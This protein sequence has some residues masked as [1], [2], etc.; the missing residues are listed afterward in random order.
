M[1]HIQYAVF[2]V[3]EWWLTKPIIL[4]RDAQEDL[5]AQP[6]PR[7]DHAKRR[8]IRRLRLVRYPCSH[9]LRRIDELE[10]R[11][12]HRELQK[13]VPPMPTSRRLVKAQSDEFSVR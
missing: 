3:Y 8:E 12:L 13:Q 2:A 6:I 5:A 4:S 9:V 11:L 1:F 10:D 7:T